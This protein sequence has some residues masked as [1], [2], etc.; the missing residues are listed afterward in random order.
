MPNPCPTTEELT[1]YLAGDASDSRFERLDEH[2]AGCVTCQAELEHLA[3]LSEPLCQLVAEA[4]QADS[5]KLPKDLQT[6]LEQIRQN[7]PRHQPLVSENTAPPTADEL[8]QIREYRILSCIGEGGMGCVYHAYDTFLQRPVAI[9]VLRRERLHKKEAVKRFLREMEVIGNLMHPSIVKALAAGEQDGLHYL[10]MEYISGVDTYQL[11]RSNGALSIADS[12][13]IILQ[14][15]RALDY[16]HSQQ[17]LHRD[18][19]SSN[20]IVNADGKVVLLDLG[21]AQFF[22]TSTETRISKTDQ[23]VGTLTYM[24]PEQLAGLRGHS[25]EAD[26]YSLGATLCEYLTGQ[27]LPLRNADN[28]LFSLISGLLPKMPPDL[29]QLI[30]S[31]I[32]SSPIDRPRSM[33]DI[34]VRV[35]AFTRGSNLRALVEQYQ[36]RMLRAASQK[37]EE[38]VIPPPIQSDATTDNPRL[39]QETPGQ[40]QE[41]LSG[42]KILSRNQHE[43]GSG[44]S[45]H[46]AMRRRRAGLAAAAVLLIA[47]P[48]VVYSVSPWGPFSPLLFGPSPN[49][50]AL[51]LGANASTVHVSSAI[52]EKTENTATLVAGENVPNSTVPIDESDVSS[53]SLEIV[54]VDE[55]PRQLLRDG[56][57]QIEKIDDKSRFTLESGFNELPLGRYRIVLDGPEELESVEDVFV[58]KG[59]AR[60]LNLT[61]ILLK[62]FQ[63]PKIPDQVGAFCTYHGTIQHIGLPK[64][65]KVGYTLRLKLL[66]SEVDSNT[67]VASKWLLVEALTHHPTGD[68][69]ESGYLK[70][71]NEKW[72]NDKNL[73]VLEGW[74]VAS[75]NI[76]AQYMGEYYPNANT[77]DLIVPFDPNE[78]LLKSRGSSVLPQSRISLHD[79]LVLFFGDES[80]LAAHDT[81]KKLRPELPTMGVRHSWIDTIDAGRG[82]SECYIVSSR[83]RSKNISE[84]APGFFM[85]RNKRATF[86]F[87]ELRVNSPILTAN[88]VVKNSDTVKVNAEEIRQLLT[89]IRLAEVPKDASPILVGRFDLATLPE[90]GDSANWLGHVTVGNSPSQTIDARVTLLGTE[91]YKEITGRWLNIQ[92]K[93]NYVGTL[94][95][96]WENAYLLIDEEA[97]KKENFRILK[98]WIATQDEANVFPIPENMNLDSIIDE[99]IALLEEPG[100]KLLGVPEVLS[101]LFHAK[102]EPRSMISSLREE[103]GAV[104]GAD[105]RRVTLSQ[106]TIKS[107]QN[108]K[109]Q[110]WEPPT[111]PKFNYQFTRS[112]EIPFGIVQANLDSSGPVRIDIEFSLDSYNKADNPSAESLIF[113]ELKWIMAAET[114]HTQASEALKKKNW[115]VWEWRQSDK[116]STKVFKVYAE[117]CGILY[118]NGEKG[119]RTRGNNGN[120]LLKN[121]A[122]EFL[123]IPLGQLSQDDIDYLDNGRYW[124]TAASVNKQFH[125]DKLDF[126]KITLRRITDGKPMTFSV[127]SLGIDDKDW[128]M[129]LNQTTW[130]QHT[131]NRILPQDFEFADYVR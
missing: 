79:F 97:Y 83:D 122:G 80:I 70:I 131:E 126:P 59:A 17:V 8:V 39:E 50:S 47:L 103:I 110:I 23:A 13:E 85:A 99:R 48:P 66:T 46:G 15:A 35:S 81:I 117:Y 67:G 3:S 73:K 32:A 129:R 21:L 11:R 78:D 42:D 26:I 5:P 102:L 114:T 2:I 104:A 20:L 128:V 107:G 4:V 69:V 96:N 72:E 125:L 84:D 24:A 123:Q 9:K 101:M 124:P 86:G 49:P 68:L 113:D 115:R 36:T 91:I 121:R 45:P 75:S 52:A 111:N 92:V 1:R 14:A 31:M 53:G 65:V 37:T 40:F 58:A 41:K 30:R 87:V 60:R 18:I 61:A 74:V 89:S 130:E 62:P 44:I 54:A 127:S 29:M 51:H 33:R 19:K 64:G 119:T 88:C 38:V 43:N 93:S 100:L 16:A 90:N 120:V 108:I 55:I 118:A 98:G 106:K 105:M 25:I 10:V 76:I 77:K 109:T 56:R 71:D 112:K 6:A 95:Q 34:V 57:V 94:S 7:R 116:Y 27:K 28:D 12:C 63:Y 22:G 82:P